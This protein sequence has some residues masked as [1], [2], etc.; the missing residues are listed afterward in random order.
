[1]QVYYWGFRRRERSLARQARAREEELRRGEELA[2][3][4]AGEEQ[5]KIEAKIG[6]VVPPEQ[7]PKEP[8]LADLPDDPVHTRLP[9]EDSTPDDLGYATPEPG[10]APEDVAQPRRHEPAAPHDVQSEPP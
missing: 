9:A 10:I 4:R 2:A 7:L 8:A 1:M 3:F 5:E 6:A